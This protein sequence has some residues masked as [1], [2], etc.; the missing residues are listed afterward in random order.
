MNMGEKSLYFKTAQRFQATL[1]SQHHSMDHFNIVP[2]YFSGAVPHFFK[3]HIILRYLEWTQPDI[4]CS[5]RHTLISL[6]YYLFI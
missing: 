1:L 2:L 4:S 5:Y 6:Y 3:T